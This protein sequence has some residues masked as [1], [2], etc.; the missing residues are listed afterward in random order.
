[1]PCCSQCIELLL[2]YSDGVTTIPAGL[3]AATGFTATFDPSLATPDYTYTY[4]GKSLTTQASI[5]ALLH[6]TINGADGV[7]YLYVDCNSFGGGSCNDICETVFSI[8]E[9]LDYSADIPPD[10]YVHDSSEG[11]G[12]GATVEDGLSA[13]TAFSDIANAHTAPSEGVYWFDLNGQ[14]FQTHVLT[15]GW[16]LGV[17]DFG[18][19]SGT[20]TEST[21]MSDAARGILPDAA[22]AEFTNADQLRMLHSGGNVDAVSS[23]ATNVSRFVSA[24]TIMAGLNDNANNNDWTGVGQAMLR[25]DATLTATINPLGE[26]VFAPRA[27][28]VGGNLHWRNGSPNILRAPWSAGNIPASESFQLYARVQTAPSGPTKEVTLIADHAVTDWT[29]DG[30]TYTPTSSTCT[31]PCVHALE[32]AARMQ[33]LESQV[34]N[35]TANIDAVKCAGECTMTFDV[36]PGTNYTP[37]IPAGYTATD[38]SNT[39]LVDYDVYITNRNSGTFSSNVPLTI[40]GDTTINTSYDQRSIVQDLSYGGRGWEQVATGV[41]ATVSDTVT[42]TMGPGTAASTWL[43]ADAILITDGTNNYVVDDSHAGWSALTGSWTHQALGYLN[44][45]KYIANSATT[46]S[47][48]WAATGVPRGAATDMTVTLIGPEAVNTWNIGGT[49][50]TAVTSSCEDTCSLLADLLTRV[51]ALENP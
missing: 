37:D 45:N 2:D 31:D 1:M 21:T 43:V 28:N 44:S 40:E 6:A 30:T 26:S 15:G 29:I 4:Q 35:L 51:E 20:I 23:N 33:N 9:A 41:N 25:G 14:V 11:D 49:D 24:Q 34:T 17:I 22:L 16:V 39:T 13:A 7:D 12:G 38:T 3:Y 50:Y 48:E 5:D 8:P 47:S 32:T 27:P 42:V 36:P 46:A 18:G 10:V 19:E